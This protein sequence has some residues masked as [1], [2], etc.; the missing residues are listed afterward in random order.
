MPTPLEVRVAAHCRRAGLLPP[1][2]DAERA[3]G[4]SPVSVLSRFLAAYSP[5]AHRGGGRLD[6]E[7]AARLKAQA[8]AGEDCMPS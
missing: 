7:T 6:G 8:D 5:V 3:F 2:W 1:G 4:Q